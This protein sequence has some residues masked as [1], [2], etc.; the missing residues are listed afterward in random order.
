MKISYNWLKSYLDFDLNPEVVAHYLTSC[1]LEVE[2]IETF[3]S[4]K[5]GLKGLV[6]GKV[7]TCEN[8]PDSDHL[9]LTTVDIGENFPLNIVCGASNVN[10]GQKVVVATIGTKLYHGDESFTI[11]KSKIRGKESEGMICAEDEIG[12][13]NSH[14]GIMVL[15]DDVPVGTMVSDYFEI[16]HDT[17]FEIG[18]TPNRS[19][20]ISHIG[21]ARDLRAVMLA[22]HEECSFVKQP[23]KHMLAHSVTKQK[24]DIIVENHKDCP[25]YCG[26][27]LEN[28]QVK[29][30]PKW[31]QNRLKAVGVRPINNVVDTTQYVMLAIGQ[32]LHAFDA[33]K[34]KGNKIII[35]NL[36]HGTPF[37]TLDGNELK[38]SSED[39]M[40]CDAQEGICI[41]GIY[42]GLNSGITHQTKNVFLESAYFNPVSI[43]KTAKRHGI[44]TDASFRF[45]RGCDPENCD[46]ALYVA[47]SM[48]NSYSENLQLSELIDVYPTP[49]SRAKIH[50]LYADINKIAGKILDKDTV[51]NILLNLDMEILNSSEESILVSV[52][53][54]KHDVTRPIDL[55]EEILRIY[56]YNNIEMSNQIAYP[57]S[58]VKCDTTRSNQQNISR[59]LA[60]NGFFEIMNNSLTKKN[61]AEIFTFLNAKETI[62]ILNP[63]SNEL[64]AMRQTLLF[65]GLENIIRNCN[66]K[67]VNL[68]LFEFGKTYNLN[69]EAQKS[70]D[71]TVRFSEKEQL[72]LFMTGKT[73]DDNWEAKGKI[74][75]FYFLKNIIHNILHLFHI[76]LQKTDI[77]EIRSSLP[78]TNAM[79]YT[80]EEK[81]LVSFGQIHPKI[82]KH[83]DIKKELYYAE[84]ELDTLYKNI[85]KDTVKFAPLAQYPEVERDLSLVVEK[86]VT[87]QSLEKIAY[88]YGS[89]LLKKVSLFDV[90][91]GAPLEETQKS[92]ALK[93]VL[94]HPEKT[95]TDEEI[96]KVMNKLIAAFEKDALAKLR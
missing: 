19:D 75:N 15:P 93:F 45:E 87:Y 95:L 59:F 49:I 38:L 82:L 14:D 30:S 32:P 29:E 5:G 3:E 36:S 2:G 68:R 12:I 34:I 37:T 55:I 58:T 21:V 42:G 9:H 70:E 51:V 35:K 16:E 24:I 86:H 61:Y 67:N 79:V 41:A 10:Q 89:K 72:A 94:Q 52:P 53:L 44:K 7:L 23:L 46:M 28:V 26:I 63:I 31:L 83:F 47:V 65:S 77:Q 64:S 62:N 22:N 91:E 71:V 48:L 8:H 81:I 13:G 6:V 40:I 92:Y 18:L 57:F 17:I 73:H 80:L 74:V 1:G 33:D 76:P 56:G 4:I 43:R 11:K 88:L 84:F 27:L 39:L 69:T 25:R 20:A 96:N 50:L 66:N 78:Y 85:G 60:H 54:S 90:Y